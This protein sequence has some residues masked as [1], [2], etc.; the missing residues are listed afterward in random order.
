M[1]SQPLDDLRNSIDYSL[2]PED[3]GTWQPVP[4]VILPNNIFGGPL[5]KVIHPPLPWEAPGLGGSVSN[6]NLLINPPNPSGGG[7]KGGGGVEPNPGGG[8]GASGSRG[9]VSGRMNTNTGMM[10][11]QIPIVSFTGPGQGAVDLSLQLKSLT[12]AWS[13]SKIWADNYDIRLDVSRT[14]AGAIVTFPSGL[15]LPFTRVGAP[16]LPG[17]RMFGRSAFLIHGGSAAGDSSEGCII[18]SRDIRDQIE[19]SGDD[20]LVVFDSGDPDT[21]EELGGSPFSMYKKP[22]LILRS[23]RPGGGRGPLS[24]IGGPIPREFKF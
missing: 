13:S 9:E 5:P 7:G 24:G 16:P 20:D 15:T 12:P 22:P 1:W 2:P 21:P 18:M 10:D 19:A 6:G 3:P 23:P 17:N 4:A 8:G 11:F 14:S